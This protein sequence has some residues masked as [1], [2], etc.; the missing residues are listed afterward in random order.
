M[1]RITHKEIEERG[2]IKN[3]IQTRV[4]E[5]LKTISNVWF[6]DGPVY[7]ESTIK[8][9]PFLNEVK[10]VPS[11]KQYRTD[12]HKLSFSAESWDVNGCTGEIIN[13]FEK[14]IKRNGPNDILLVYLP[15]DS[16]LWFNFADIYDPYTFEMKKGIGI[17]TGIKARL[18]EPEAEWHKD[19]NV[20]KVLIYID[21]APKWVPHGEAENIKKEHEFQYLLI[22]DLSI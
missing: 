9:I 21:G 6:I 16:G 5:W 3:H 8:E 10:L 11:Y 17:R 14:L 13:Y 19:E 22:G 2:L 18:K 1:N 7:N 12:T 15:P 20:G 4:Y